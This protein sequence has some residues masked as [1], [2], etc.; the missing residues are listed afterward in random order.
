[1]RP[2]WERNQKKQRKHMTEALR[3]YADRLIAAK[4][5]INIRADAYYGALRGCVQNAAAASSAPGQAGPADAG[6]AVAD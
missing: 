2:K 1:M 5:N 4:R 3:A 6:Q